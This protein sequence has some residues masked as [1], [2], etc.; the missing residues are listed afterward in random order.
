LRS[1]LET[2]LPADYD[3]AIQ[4]LALVRNCL[5]HAG[6][7]VDQRLAAVDPSLVRGA[8]LQISDGDLSAPMKV[9]RDVSIAVDRADQCGEI[10]RA[11]TF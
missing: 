3:Q 1:D 4:T 10:G 2:T 6:G 7:I 9:I 5:L 8:R 11:S